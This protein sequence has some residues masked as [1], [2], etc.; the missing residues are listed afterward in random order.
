M[1]GDIIVWTKSA[2][3]HFKHGDSVQQD[4][5]PMLG[6]D[7]VIKNALIMYQCIPKSC[8]SR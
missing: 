2:I 4:G 7:D 6:L 1:L 3:E 5:K 8:E